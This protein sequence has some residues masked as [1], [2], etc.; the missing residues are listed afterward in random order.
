MVRP[1]QRYARLSKARPL[2]MG[3]SA[4]PGGKGALSL[5]VNS[6]RPDRNPWM[7]FFLPP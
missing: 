7:P 1:G 6:A 2:M 4:T 5:R 3:L